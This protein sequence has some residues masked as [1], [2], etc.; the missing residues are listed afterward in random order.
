MLT[1]ADNLD[2]EMEAAVEGNTDTK[3]YSLLAG[4]GTPLSVSLPKNLKSLGSWKIRCGGATFDPGTARGSY[5]DEYTRLPDGQYR[6][7]STRMVT[8]SRINCCVPRAS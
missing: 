3:A 6:W 5:G 8:P 4:L 7:K 2:R 1:V